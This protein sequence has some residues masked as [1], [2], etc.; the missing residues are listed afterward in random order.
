MF[1]S[2][3]AVGLAAVVP[4][5]AQENTRSVDVPIRDL[6]LSDPG[7]V[8]RLNRRLSRAVHAVCEVPGVRGVAAQSNSEAC[9]VQAKAR[10]DRK[11][12]QMIAAARAAGGGQSQTARK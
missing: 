10:S 7:D 4:S 8:R 2:I 1:I 12:E 11:A 5:S 9:K 6:D 3:V